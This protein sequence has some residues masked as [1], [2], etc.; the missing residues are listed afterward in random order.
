MNMINRH[1]THPLFKLVTNDEDANI[2]WYFDH[3]K[4]FKLVIIIIIY[5][6]IYLFLCRSLNPDQF[7]NQFPCENV[8]TCKDLLV[9]V[10]R[11]TSKNHT[12]NPTSL[13]EWI[14][15]S[16]N[17][18]YELPHFVREYKRRERR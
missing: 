16:Y 15:E 7:I 10:A 14:P 1:L 11:R 6:F 12:Q 4:D 13:P 3:F 8:V 18:Y 17:L 5:L 2:L 9:N